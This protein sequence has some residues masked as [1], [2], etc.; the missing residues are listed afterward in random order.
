LSAMALGVFS[1]GEIWDGIQESWYLM[2]LRRI[3]F[4]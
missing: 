3:R 2:C 1:E 4:T